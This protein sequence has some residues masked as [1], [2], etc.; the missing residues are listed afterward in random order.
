M[1]K[2]S[3][4]LGLNARYQNFSMEYNTGRGK[5]IAASKVKTNRVLKRAGIPTPELY[6]KF[7]NARRV[8][9]YDWNSLPD[10]FVLKPSKGL[11]G[12]G[13]VVIKKRAKDGN[14]WI[15]TQRKH[16]DEDDLK[17]RALD[18]LE[19]A[20]S[21]SNVTDVAL[22]QE[23]V[24]RHKVFRKYAYRG[25]PDIR[26]IVFNKVS[27]MAMLRLPTEESGGR[28]N[29]HQGA[30]AVGV[31]IATGITTSAIWHNDPITHK[32]GTKRKLR[33]IKIPKWNTMLMMAVHCQKASGLGFMGVDIVLH[34]EK[35]PMVLEL[36]YQP[37]LT[38]QLVNK[39][40]L[41]KRLERVEDI[42]VTDA[43]H[44][45]KIAKALFAARFA[46]RVLAKQGVKTL[47]VWEQVKIVGKDKRR[48]EIRA[49]L[50]TGA[51]R[52]SIDMHLAKELGLMEKENILWSKIFKSGLG[53]QRR[54]V[55]NLTLFIAGRKI[56]TIASVAKRHNLRTPL[57]IG[58]RDLKGFLVSPRKIDQV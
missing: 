20:Y 18:I 1:V 57:I 46:D 33:G 39:A 55:I 43:E 58:R 15:T 45:V 12:E 21:M 25:T 9:N 2:A 8:M 41:K 31:D 19:G 38:I 11:G 37:G 22:V 28:A 47:N 32:P 16:I 24:G 49:K 48:H 40:G 44:G 5:A 26:I 53:R 52:S 54:Y 35:G 6:A 29:L 10:S 14:G 4:L 34:P 7:G 56:K 3:S 50:D 23:F 30:I 36:N 42:E 51:W 17:L 13:I 27:V